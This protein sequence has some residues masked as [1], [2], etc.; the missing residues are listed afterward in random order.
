LRSFPNS[1]NEGR[2]RDTVIKRIGPTWVAVDRLRPEL[3]G[4]RLNHQQA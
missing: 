3:T 1:T 2:T 4:C